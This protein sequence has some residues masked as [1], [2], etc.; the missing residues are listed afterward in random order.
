MGLAS[1]PVTEQADS[2]IHKRVDLEEVVISDFKQ[3][4]SLYQ[5]T[6]VSHADIRLLRNQEVTSL[7]ELTGVFP[8]F[9]MPDYGSRQNTPVFIRGVGA[10]TK[11]PAVGFY[12]D[13]VP[14]FETSAFD[15]DMSDIA[16]VEVYRGPQGT[17]YGRNAIGGIINV[18]THSPLDYQKTR[19][20][21]GYGTYNDITAQA[22][23]Y[24][25]L[26]NNFGVSIAADFHHNNGYFR[27]VTTGDKADD[28]NSGSG[29]VGFYW[30]PAKQWL[31]H[32]N[33][34]LDYSD[35]GGYP[36]A[37]YDVDAD[38]L[39]D[40]D[41][42]RYSHYRRLVSTTGLNAR[43][44]GRRVSFN[45]QTSIQY[46]KDN[47]GIDQ[48]FTKTDTYFVT[49]GIHQNL[50]SQEF[51]LKSNTASRYQWLVGVFG[52]IQKNKNSQCTNNFTAGNAQPTFYRIPTYAY[53][54]YHQSQ[55]NIWRGLSATAGLRFD[56]EYTKT[57]YNREKVMLDGSGQSHVRDFRST[58]HFHQLT[59][60][61][62]LQYETTE[63]N[64][65]Y[66]SV[67][68]GYKAG[69]FNQTFQEDHERTYAPEY[70][71]NYEI[72]TKL[73]LLQ[74]HLTAELALF[75]IDWRHQQINYT[76][77]GLGNVLTNAG[78][79]DSKGVELNIGVKPV[80]DLQVDLSYGYTYARFLTYHK[81]ETQDL[82][83]KLLPMVPRNTLSLNATYTIFPTALCDKIVISAGTTGIGKIYWGEDNQ[84]AQDFYCLLN[85]KVSLTKGIFTWD[86]WGKNI[87][88][89]DYLS[90]GFA[91]GAGYKGQAGR[92]ATFGMSLSVSF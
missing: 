43:Y 37:V 81:S 64:F 32:L 48:D 50:F 40:I 16:A 45:S 13:G 41:Y 90:Y 7:K 6:S 60:K 79:S 24:Q 49:N 4:A 34:M 19:I 22:S 11:G 73:N 54:L 55:Y 20:K 85:A 44:D 92:P 38:K 78:H 70:S 56:Y 80:R 5:P 9:Y 2:G 74:N 53:A 58:L 82:S 61:F 10:K 87:T 31:L 69:G 66:A 89:T 23:T 14:H 29:R 17:L 39:A 91:S 51:T 28:I 36:Y 33:S 1:N 67:T 42:N 88:D 86:I 35:Q 83:G 3:P 77:P 52:I 76:V 46:I 59:P 72:G 57:S 8:N 18:Y 12:V 71:W 30:R 15:I 84:V 25:K 75:Y 68:R 63:K 27:N 62:S 21:L 47:Q 26:T 65:Y